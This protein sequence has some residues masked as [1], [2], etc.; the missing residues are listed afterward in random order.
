MEMQRSL[1][2]IRSETENEGT[3]KMSIEEAREQALNNL[4]GA[5]NPFGDLAERKREVINGNTFTSIEW[6]LQVAH[7]PSTTQE[8][9]IKLM[10]LG[11]SAQDVVKTSGYSPSHVSGAVSIAR[12]LG[13][14]TSDD[15]VETKRKRGV[16]MSTDD[17]RR[18]TSLSEEVLAVLGITG[19]DRR[20][21]KG[22]ALAKIA[23]SPAYAKMK[24]AYDLRLETAKRNAE[25]EARKTQF[26]KPEESDTGY[27]SNMYCTPAAKAA[28]MRGDGK[29]RV[30]ELKL[31]M[32]I[33][34][35]QDFVKA[36]NRK[37]D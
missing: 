8:M 2:Q 25:N 36:V 32:T 12:S 14:I 4:I 33:E 1:N 28:E 20:R 23:A 16:R 11:M 17:P 31:V 3:T 13:V 19:D 22:D 34:E 9:I 37:K 18:Y 21:P 26:V 5:G 29:D 27:I 15:H 30:I 7:F 24:K 35:L 10:K 6:M